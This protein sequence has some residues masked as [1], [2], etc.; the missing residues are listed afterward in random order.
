MWTGDQARC[1]GLRGDPSPAIARAAVGQQGQLVLAGATTTAKLEPQG[2][3][4]GEN[5]LHVLT[6]LSKQLEYGEEAEESKHQ[7]LEDTG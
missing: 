5:T 3:W 2:F 4:L 7:V 6:I 1:F